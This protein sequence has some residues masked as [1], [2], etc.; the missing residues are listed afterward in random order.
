MEFCEAPCLT[1]VPGQTCAGRECLVEHAQ[2]SGEEASEQLLILLTPVVRR[3]AQR[4][5]GNG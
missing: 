3:Q 5:C 4:L 2:R 1:G